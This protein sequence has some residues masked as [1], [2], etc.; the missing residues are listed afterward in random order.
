[1]EIKHIVVIFFACLTFTQGQQCNDNRY[2]LSENYRK[3][4]LPPSNGTPVQ[5][6]S[7]INLRNILNVDEKKQEISVEI[8]FRL[9]WT[10]SRIEPIQKYLSGSDVRGRYIPLASTSG[11]CFWM[12]DIFI[13]Q[14]IK[15][16]T[17]TY[18]TKP[19]SLRIYQ[20]RMLR[21]S[22]R[23]NFDVACN[24]NFHRFPV[25][26][27]DC[28][29]RFESFDFTRKHMEISWRPQS[30]MTIN[31]NI[32]LTQF[33]SNISLRTYHTV[34]YEQ[35]YPGIILNIHLHREITYHL[36]RSYFPSIMF[37][38]ISWLSLFL[39]P[40]YVPGRV[41]MFMTAL[42]SL[43][44]MDSSVQQTMP[45]VNYLTLL[46]IWMV[47]C[48]LFVFICI[49]E[50][51]LVTFLI[52]IEKQSYAVKAELTCRICIAIFFVIFFLIYWLFIVPQ[53]CLG[54]CWSSYF[55]RKKTSL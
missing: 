17:P 14:A 26:Q 23:I 50:F 20:S 34:Y 7:S 43:V 27:Q 24:M 18:Y 10:D 30:E 39:P 12:P 42:L 48:M 2:V 11:E 46:D 9:Y 44:S 45:Q 28:V 41:L 15:L 4:D 49:L 21:F 6:S 54:E 33:I 35:D 31:P 32:S 37:V 53:Y 40:E 8:T 13:D 16:R 5:L 36:F 51:I 19:A 29:I 3:Q 55:Y 25:D 38:G 52:R 47:I 1:M 22:K